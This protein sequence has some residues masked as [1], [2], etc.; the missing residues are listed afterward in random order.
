MTGGSATARLAE[1]PEAMFYHLTRRP[2]ETVVPDLLMRCLARNW[3][4]TLRSV[5]AERA[6]AL[7]AHLWSFRDEAFL[8]HGLPDDGHAARQPIYLTSGL[9]RPNAPDVLMLVESAGASDAEFAAHRRVVALFDGHDETAVAQA[10]GLW[11]QA[12]AAGAL[13]VYWAEEEGG[14]WVRR[15]DSG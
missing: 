2:L 14:R 4:V 8:P 9:E 3:R 6:A 10:R 1:R 15:A 7:S 13:A 12:V 11:R 5:T